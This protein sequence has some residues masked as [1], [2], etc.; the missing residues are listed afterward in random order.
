MY[1]VF[2]QEVALRLGIEPQN[3]RV[4]MGDTR[5]PSGPLAGGSTGSASGCC[6]IMLAC[7]KLLAQLHISI[8]ADK[9]TRQAAFEKL[10][11]GSVEALGD[12]APPGSKTGS[13]AGA[14]QGKPEISGGVHGP[15]TMF[16]FGAEF[17]EV[18][19]NLRTREIRCPRI[20]GAFAA[21]RILNPRLA[22]SQLMGGMI[23]GISSALHE[24]TE[25]DQREARY[26]N[27]NLAEYLIPVNA[28]I[29]EVTVIMVPE[30]DTEVNAAG[31]KGVGE[32]GNVGTAAAIANAVYHATGKRFR[33]LPIRIEDLIGT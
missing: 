30:I 16:A 8:A 32:L 5:L 31:V 19:I 11:V 12:Y 21:G 20:V 14:Y 2:Q 7:E 26:V 18:R 17:V 13:T 24:A 9:F 6:A 4:E 33:K 23:W 29:G 10:K 22:H 1:T 3:V 27:D 28:D 25:I 15:K